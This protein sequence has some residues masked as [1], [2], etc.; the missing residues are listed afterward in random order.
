MQAYPRPRHRKCS[1][2]LCSVPH[3]TSIERLKL[4]QPKFKGGLSQ[5]WPP[6]L[7]LLQLRKHLAAHT[8]LYCSST[9]STVIISNVVFFSLSLVFRQGPHLRMMFFSLRF[10]P[11]LLVVDLDENGPRGLFISQQQFFAATLRG[12]QHQVRRNVRRTSSPR[13]S[14]VHKLGY[15]CGFG[16]LHL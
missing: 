16:L 9:S 13:T 7:S 8:L 4:L 11:L 12:G 15:F 10:S 1:S 5:P 2:F 3:R 6:S 14:S